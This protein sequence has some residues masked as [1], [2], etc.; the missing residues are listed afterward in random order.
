MALAMLLL[1]LTQALRME[2][3]LRQA[4]SPPQSTRKD[5][6]LARLQGLK[7]ALPPPQH[8]QVNLLAKRQF[9]FTTTNSPFA[10]TLSYGGN[11][12][13]YGTTRRMMEGETTTPN[14]FFTT[15]TTTP[16]PFFTTTP[17]PK[18]CKW[19]KDSEGI[20]RPLNCTQSTVTDNPWAGWNLTH[21]PDGTRR[22]NV[23]NTS[24]VEPVAE[25]E[26]VWPNDIRITS[27]KDLLSD[28]L[29]RRYPG[30]VVLGVKEGE[31]LRVVNGP[32]RS[33]GG[34]YIRIQVGGR[35]L[36]NQ[37][38]KPDTEL[39]GADGH[40]VIRPTTR[41]VTVCHETPNRIF[42]DL[43]DEHCI[44]PFL[45]ACPPNLGTNQQLYKEQ[46]YWNEHGAEKNVT[47]V[48]GTAPINGSVPI[49]TWGEDW[50]PG[51][52]VAY[53]TCN[54]GK[55]SDMTWME[56]G[57]ARNVNLLCA[58]LEAIALLRQM[59]HLLNYEEIKL[60]ETR[61]IDYKWIDKDANYRML[62]LTNAMDNARK[63]LK[64]TNEGQ[65]TGVHALQMVVDALTEFRLVPGG[66]PHS[67]KTCKDFEKHWVYALPK[68]DPSG[69][70]FQNYIPPINTTISAD[71]PRATPSAQDI[72]IDQTI[73]FTCS[74]A[75]NKVGAGFDIMTRQPLFNYRDGCMCQSRWSGGCPFK[76]SASPNFKV[77]S[78]D[79]LD[80]KFVAA[81]RGAPTN[82][83]CWYW[84]KNDHP[85]WGY[86]YTP[87]GTAY[88]A[89]A[90][91]STD[92]MR[93]WTA[94][95]RAAGQAR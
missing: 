10:T 37:T 76:M 65:V 92:L 54:G 19:K 62:S 93:A 11:I 4:S 18:P 63:F 32:G 44:P 28:T 31:W 59:S 6:F 38:D 30:D 3:G 26:V 45:K 86:L 67:E 42:S 90:K 34:G 87:V 21:N 47:C 12:M 27:E 29:A 25:W 53:S 88:T 83:L 22:V 43:R 5:N 80:E 13:G 49:T 71:H 75:V 60:K 17:P 73:E 85:E 20:I 15:M 46:G 33:V 84:S 94:K 66:E 35:P 74:Y 2:D 82:A 91:N 24:S 64:E 1:S 51:T 9:P 40:I 7:Q 95:R 50:Y 89:P 23:T 79:S 8:T 81:R 70:G 14:P 16:N 41:I 69:L 48:E 61:A 72:T 55:W 56:W 57:A 78:F 39:V 52:R 68:E 36:V 77:F 58:P